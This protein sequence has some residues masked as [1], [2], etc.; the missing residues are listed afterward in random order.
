MLRQ[1]I[2]R[3]HISSNSAPPDFTSTKLGSGTSSCGY[4]MV[5]SRLQATLYKLITHNNLVKWSGSHST[6]PI[7]FNK[8]KIYW[9]SFKIAQ[10]E[11]TFRLKIFTNKWLSADTATS[12]IMVNRKQWE[13][14]NFPQCNYNDEHLLYILA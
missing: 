6:P 13:G 11:D 5:T 4:T 2:L 10:K 9:T 8:S 14:S 3:W 1:K 7:D 12:R